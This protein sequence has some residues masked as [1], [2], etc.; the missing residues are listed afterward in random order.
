MR[1]EGCSKDDINEAAVAVGVRVNHT[2]DD[3]F[4][5]KTSGDRYKRIGRGGRTVPGAVCWHGHR[6]FFRVLFNWCPD[7]MVETALA[8]Y[9]GKNHFEET[10]EETRGML[11]QQYYG[12]HVR[13]DNAPCVCE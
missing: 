1:Y 7:A 2:G 12:D 13:P 11:V 6:D 4:R 10:H 8:T 5:L 9:N 3:R